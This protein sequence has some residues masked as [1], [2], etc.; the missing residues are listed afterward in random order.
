[1]H[2][3][4]MEPL[5][6]NELVAISP[7]PLDR[8]AASREFKKQNPGRYCM[9][10]GDYVKAQQ[11]AL[12]TLDE[13][14]RGRPFYQF[15]EQSKCE[16][17]IYY[18]D[19][20]TG[21]RCRTRPDML[22]D[23]FIFDIKTTRH[24]GPREFAFDAERLH[25]DLSAYMYLLSDLL[26]RGQDCGSLLELQQKPSKRFVVVSITNTEPHG[27][28]FR[29]AS[30]NFITNG[31]KKYNSAMKTIAACMKADYWPSTSGELELDIEHWQQFDAKRA[32]WLVGLNATALEAA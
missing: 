3:L 7:T 17:S 29:P 12:R 32:P 25:Y 26:L 8:S 27:I 11:L 30:D 19:P 31:Q 16:Q 6:I 18:T 10:M 1:M 13:R 14:F 2:A 9:W 21:L 15:V 20:V 5:T 23:E 24:C 4:V 22:H 28:F